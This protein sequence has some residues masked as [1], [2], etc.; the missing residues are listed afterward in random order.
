MADHATNV[1]VS[2]NGEPRELEGA[3]TVRRTLEVLGLNPESVAVELNRSI[4]RK[5]SF[6][7]V[8]LSDGDEIEIV[9]FVG[10]G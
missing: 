6:D 10:G 5:D 1:T 7:S 9:E 8:R 2:I 4:L 3:P